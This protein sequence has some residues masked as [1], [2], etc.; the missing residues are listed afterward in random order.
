MKR[1]RKWPTSLLLAGIVFVGGDA[2]ARGGKEKK[3]VP[4]QMNVILLGKTQL[5]ADAKAFRRFCKKNAGRKRSELRTEIVAQ[6]KEIAKKEQAA[7]L[8]A[9]GSPKGARSL[10]VVNA[11]ALSLSVGEI[12]KA[13][14]L[15]QVK[16]VYPANNLP[17]EGPAGSVGVVLE[18]GRREPFSAKR[19]TI[20]WNIKKLNVPKVWKELKI[21]G[22]GVV[23]AMFDQGINYKHEDL[24]GNIWINE[25]EK[26]NNGKDDDQNGLV[27]DYYGFNFTHHKAEV[28]PVGG[29]HG[30]L[31]SSV[32]AGDG[33][34]GTVTGVAP[35]AKLMGLIAWGGPYVAARAFQYALEQGA[36][37]VS[38]S[39]SIPG[40]GHTRG[41][42]RLM[43]EQ[44]TCAGLVLISGA[45]NFQRK[46]KIPV[47]IRIPEG[48]PCV[49]CIGGVNEK[50]KIP[51]FVSF[52]PVEWSKVKFYEDY[53]MPKGLVK[54][55]VCAFPGPKIGLI[56][57]RADTGYL[58]DNNQFHG[59]SLS[60]PHVAGVCALILQANPELLPWRIKEILEETATD[61][62]PRGKDTETGAGLV[63]AYKAVQKALEEK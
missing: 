31:T 56:S 13:R 48:I 10:W 45:G 55:D 43:A 12:E 4:G 32:V 52:G 34:G 30:T 19:K 1:T 63:H 6:L 7:I 33:T 11:I 46:A 59:N 44:A 16:W 5:L 2:A 40:L 50:M 29:N 54:P 18:P 38:M 27:D 8:K 24:R 41:L 39:F 58:P 21:T 36:D 35:R 51:R 15:K 20:P 23:V 53:P 37:I 61:I 62:R 9:M 60:A 47:Q 26:P 25:K 3:R 49:I 57:P 22:E 42:W 14:K 28:A 17:A